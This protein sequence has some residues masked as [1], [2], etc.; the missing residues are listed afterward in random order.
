MA[1]FVSKRRDFARSWLSPGSEAHGLCER[2]APSPVALG[3]V[4]L[5]DKGDGCGELRRMMVDAR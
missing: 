3:Q 2:C 5:E 4:A 1:A